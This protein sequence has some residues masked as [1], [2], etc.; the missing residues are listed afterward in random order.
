MQREANCALKMK[1][2]S[3]Y[4]E[5]VMMQ[6]HPLPSQSD[7]FVLKKCYKAFILIWFLGSISLYEDPKII[8]L[9]LLTIYVKNLS[10][11][12]KFLIIFLKFRF[13]CF[14]S[15]KFF[16]QFLV[17]IFPCGSEPIDPHIYV[18]PDSKSLMLPISSALKFN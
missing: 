5:K 10:E 11:E 15:K 4:L 3:Y 18:D 2:K 1:F 9:L 14:E 8:F 17:D 16:L 13:G 6:K 12:R 7:Y